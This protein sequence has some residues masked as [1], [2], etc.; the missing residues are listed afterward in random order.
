MEYSQK[1][2]NIPKNCKFGEAIQNSFKSIMARVNLPLLM[3]KLTCDPAH[4]REIVS[5]HLRRQSFSDLDYCF[6]DLVAACPDQIDPI[7]RA[8][9]NSTPSIPK[10]KKLMTMYYDHFKHCESFDPK[11][12]EYSCVGHCDPL[13]MVKNYCA[14]QS[15]KGHDDMK[16]IFCEVD[17]RVERVIGKCVPFFPGYGDMVSY[18]AGHTVPF[19]DY[20]DQLAAHGSAVLNEKLTQWRGSILLQISMGAKRALAWDGF[21]ERAKS[22]HET[23]NPDVA[24]VN[25]LIASFVF[26]PK[27]TKP[28]GWYA[29]ALPRS[30]CEDNYRRLEAEL[31]QAVESRLR[32]QDKVPRKRQ[33]GPLA[34]ASRGPME[35]DSE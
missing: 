9:G 14:K 21:K 25:R 20:D 2:Q 1:I 32:K 8:T 3:M 19:R 33:R 17:V 34:T 7:L 11:Y 15:K 18:A 22:F 4:R 28:A 12:L 26:P 16:R 24:G 5:D 31:R 13:F 23:T 35:T 10:I 6:W 27:P 30:F 29:F